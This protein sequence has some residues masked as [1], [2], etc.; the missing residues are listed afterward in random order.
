M[1]TRIVGERSSPYIG[2]SLDSLYSDS[3]E[4][5]SGIA[6]YPVMEDVDG[7]LEAT[8]RGLG[9]CRMTCF[10]MH[11]EEVEIEGEVEV[12]VHRPQTFARRGL[13]SHP[14]AERLETPEEAYTR[15]FSSLT[16]LRRNGLDAESSVEGGV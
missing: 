6:I 7:Y 10:W 15:R 4:D 12:M 14:D 2:E 8:E 1:S 11:L 3:L 9:F 5:V 16:V 13:A